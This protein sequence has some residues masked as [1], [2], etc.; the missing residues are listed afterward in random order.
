MVQVTV[1]ITMAQILFGVPFVGSVGLFAVAT[2]LFI[3]INL[4]IG[5][6]FSTLAQNQLQAMQMSIFFLLPSILLSGILYAR[7]GMPLIFQ[8]ISLLIP[9]TYYLQILR[10]VILKGVD[11]AHARSTSELARTVEQGS[12]ELLEHPERIL[13][14]SRP[15]DDGAG[16]DRDAPPPAVPDGGAPRPDPLEV[17]DGCGELAVLGHGEEKIRTPVWNSKPTGARKAP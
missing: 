1:I 12:L 5:F 13:D 6:A 10:G 8:W 15:P 11:V 3:T 2:L 14:A 4:A 9:M 17:L 16:K 7:E